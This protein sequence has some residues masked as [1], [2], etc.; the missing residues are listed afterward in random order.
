MRRHQLVMGQEHS[1]RGKGVMVSRASVWVQI[2]I[3]LLMDRGTL[4]GDLASLCLC[5]STYEMRLVNI[6]ISCNHSLLFFT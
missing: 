3:L 6:S 1:R 2:L 5:F 4:T